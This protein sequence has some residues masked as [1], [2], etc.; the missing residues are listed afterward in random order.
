M[1]DL[2]TGLVGHWPL[3]R[4]TEDH[5]PLSHKSQAADVDLGLAG[6]DGEPNGA[7]RFN[8]RSSVVEV[9]DHDA[10][11][12]RKG[13]FSVAAWVCTDEKD[14]DVVGDLVSKFDPD[15]R[16]G[17]QLSVVSN[18]G[19]TSTSQPNYRNPISASTMRGWMRPGPTADVRATLS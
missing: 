4:D 14:G 16:N 15:R 19:V 8:G 1:A 2:Q 12:F 3:D 10:L 9:A 17:M 13:E 6:R 5:S 11:R 18:S 7:A